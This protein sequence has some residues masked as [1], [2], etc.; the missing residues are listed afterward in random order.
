M[1][2]VDKKGVQHWC[3][4][5]ENQFSPRET[6]PRGEAPKQVPEQFLAMA[7]RYLRALSEESTDV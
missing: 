1:A 5:V 2:K 4:S 6:V 7:L 3:D